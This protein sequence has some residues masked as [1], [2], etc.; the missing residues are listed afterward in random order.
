MIT[1]AD[2]LQE[3]NQMAAKGVLS[4]DEHD[5]LKRLFE[6]DSPVGRAAGG[7]GPERLRRACRA[8]KAECPQ[9]DFFCFTCG[10]DLGSQD[11]PSTTTR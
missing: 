6:L 4:K 10:C 5:R 1:D 7:D 9:D 2:V 3:I 11:Q 8:C